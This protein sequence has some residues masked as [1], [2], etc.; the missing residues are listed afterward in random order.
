M[1][2]VLDVYFNFVEYFIRISLLFVIIMKEIKK[3]LNGMKEII[4][5][6]IRNAKQLNTTLIVPPHHIH[7]H[8]RTQ[9]LR[10]T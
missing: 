7:K 10:E 6:K 3:T 5:A 8:A 1:E 9:E 4:C 2:I